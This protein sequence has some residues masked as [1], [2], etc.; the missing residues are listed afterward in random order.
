MSIRKSYPFEFDFEPSVGDRI[1]LIYTKVVYILRLDL[2]KDFSNGR[3]LK[4]NELTL[5]STYE[6][7][8]KYFV[9]DGVNLWQVKIINNLGKPIW[10]YLV[11]FK[12][13][14]NSL[15]FILS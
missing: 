15:S 5:S 14:I 6:V 7:L 3:Y 4:K 2:K 9:M 11:F 8:E 12:K 10:V 13:N 1:T